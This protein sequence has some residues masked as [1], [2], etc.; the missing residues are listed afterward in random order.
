[1][2]FQIFNYFTESLGDILKAVVKSPKNKDV[3][4]WRQVADPDPASE[5]GPVPD[6]AFGLG[7]GPNNINTVGNTSSSKR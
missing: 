2:T 3:H 5:H 6:P 1:M 4:V 7:P